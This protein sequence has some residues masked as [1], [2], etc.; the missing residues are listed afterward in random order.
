MGLEY[1]RPSCKSMKEPVLTR[2]DY[3]L[4]HGQVSTQWVVELKVNSIVIID[5]QLPN[6]QLMKTIFMMSKPRD[7]TLDIVT[8][9]EAARMWN[10]GW[11]NE[12]GNVM[13]LFRST[14][15]ARKAYEAG[16]RFQNLQVGNMP[17]GPGKVCVMDVIYMNEDD[18]KNVDAVAKA[19][20]NVTLKITPEFASFK[21]WEEAKKTSFP[22]LD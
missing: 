11:F 19:G 5:D 21:T 6:D 1:S 12:H 13:I 9:D 4:I 14:A 16:V 3:R 10:D 7:N 17:G 2:I 8:C 15:M 20:C 22:D 18:A